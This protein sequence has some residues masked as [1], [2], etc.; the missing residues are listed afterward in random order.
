[1]LVVNEC[2]GREAI[3]EAWAG[4]EL[5]VDDTRNRG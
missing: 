1:M 4:C 5:P 2:K 3:G